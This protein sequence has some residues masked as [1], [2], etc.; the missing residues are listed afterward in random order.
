MDLLLT[1][2]G[3]LELGQSKGRRQE[4]L[5]L[6]HGFWGPRD[7][8]LLLPLSQAISRMLVT[9]GVAQTTTCAYMGASAAGGSFMCY[10][11]LLSLRT[12]LKMENLLLFVVCYYLSL[13]PHRHWLVWLIE[14]VSQMMFSR[15]MSVTMA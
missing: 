10:V 13:M 3:W 6:P 11:T 12:F 5:G 4:L 14:A 9:S 1:W 15:I 8:S 2:P 7:L